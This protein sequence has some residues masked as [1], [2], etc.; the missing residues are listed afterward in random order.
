MNK[1]ILIV[2]K[3][4]NDY[5]SLKKRL[6][7]LGYIVHTFTDCNE[8]I[9]FFTLQP[10]LLICD[11]HLYLLFESDFIGKMTDFQ[12]DIPIIMTGFSKIEEDLLMAFAK[13]AADFIAKP[14][15]S[16]EV[17]A[18]VKAIFRRMGMTTNAQVKKIK[19]GHYT[20][21][22]EQYE[23]DLNTHSI[24]LSKKELELL[25][26]LIERKKISREEILWKLWGIGYHGGLRIV[27]VNISK[28]RKKIEKNPKKPQY[29]KTIKGY[30]YRLD[31]PTEKEG[32]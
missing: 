30:G 10:N 32:Y 7:Q 4:L 24:T 18:R 31:V 29:I 5:N 8:S 15:H 16:R 9:N 3:Q 21:I 17:E 27:D 13:G 26:L 22:P 28:L 14:F 19:M 25:L 23:M 11:F 1:T 20:L 12:Q 6:E 2:D